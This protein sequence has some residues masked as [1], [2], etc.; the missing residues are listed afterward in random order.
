MTKLAQLYLTTVVATPDLPDS[1]SLFNYLVYNWN[2]DVLYRLA[3]SGIG[4]DV[5]VMIRL[6]RIEQFPY[7]VGECEIALND[8]T[9]TPIS[10]L[11]FQQE[12]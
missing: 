3:G 2:E 11:L 4:F 7:M 8:V 1:N 10:G 9:T 12:N 5:M 6:D